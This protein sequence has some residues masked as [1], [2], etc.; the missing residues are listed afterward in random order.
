VVTRARSRLL[1]AKA[2]AEALS[3]SLDAAFEEDAG[4]A[5]RE[6]AV[7]EVDFDAHV[8]LREITDNPILLQRLRAV[9]QGAGC[10]MILPRGEAHSNSKWPDSLVA[11][12]RRRRVRE[13]LTY[14]QLGAAT[15]G[16]KNTVKKWCRRQQRS[17]TATAGRD[18]DLILLAIKTFTIEE[19]RRPTAKMSRPTPACLPTGPSNA[20]SG[21]GRRPWGK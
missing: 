6:L 12:V 16:P 1:N 7:A 15:G 10:S 8:T 4:H 21:P 17:S 3:S 18:G 13:S 5:P 20:T 2:R 14:K 11:E 9:Q 19:G